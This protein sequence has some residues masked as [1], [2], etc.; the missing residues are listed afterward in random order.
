M[1]NTTNLPA[2]LEAMA[3]YAVQAFGVMGTY[4]D[5][6]VSHSQ[7]RRLSVSDRRA[8]QSRIKE[9]VAATCTYCGSTQCRGHNG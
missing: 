6:M 9:I 1:T 2:N 3:Q 7:M 8:V 4:T 5:Q